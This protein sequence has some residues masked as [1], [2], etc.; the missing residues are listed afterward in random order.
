LCV[1]NK[2]PYR[3][4]HLRR[5]KGTQHETM[6]LENKQ[7]KKK[8][9]NGYNVIPSLNNFAFGFGFFSILTLNPMLSHYPSSQ[10]IFLF[11]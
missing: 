9:G 10:S 7:N 8:L 1:G 3:D 11:T 2:N 4:V 6:R 5:Q